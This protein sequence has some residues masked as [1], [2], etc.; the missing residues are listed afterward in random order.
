MRLR[1]TS[2]RSQVGRNSA[3]RCRLPMQQASEL[4]TQEHPSG[5]LD[6]SGTPFVARGDYHDAAAKRDRITSSKDVG[7]DREN[8]LEPS[9]GQ[10][11]GTQVLLFFLLPID[12]LSESGFR[13]KRSRQKN[14][15][16]QRKEK[17][18]QEINSVAGLRHRSSDARRCIPPEVACHDIVVGPENVE[19]R[20]GQVQ[21]T[22]SR[23]RRSNRIQE[24]G[25]VLNVFQDVEQSNRVNRA[26]FET[27]IVKCRVD[28]R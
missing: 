14:R 9:P 4:S 20:N 5:L 27:G 23:Q 21:P 7:F 28:D 25:I 11:A 1:W 6:R 2:T 22:A 3:C 12:R 18:R 13:W 8:L 16:R 24:C 17:M 19:G 10:A 15:Q 26:F